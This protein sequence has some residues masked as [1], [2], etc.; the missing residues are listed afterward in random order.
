GYGESGGGLA[1]PVFVDFMRMAL[2]GRPP[3][4]FR[5]PEGMRL[6]AVDRR[7]G[8]LA[9]PGASG[10]TMEAF[11]P[12]TAPC[13]DDCPVIDDQGLADIAGSDTDTRVVPAALRERLLANPGLY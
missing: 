1:A 13:S 5:P 9:Q 3:T 8:R 2:E 4:E 12:G 7:T 11:K 6:L 10:T